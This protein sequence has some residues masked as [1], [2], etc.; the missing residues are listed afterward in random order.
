MDF[1][2]LQASAGSKAGAQQTALS[3]PGTLGNQVLMQRRKP[4]WDV[5]PSESSREG[6]LIAWS[7]ALSVGD[8]EIDEQ[9][10]Q[11]VRMINTLHKAMRDGTTSDVMEK[12]FN[13]LAQYT[14]DHF[15]YEEERMA[16]CGYPHLVEHR[17]QHVNLVQQVQALQ[18][19]FAGG[20]QRINMKVMN[21]LKNWITGHI[22]NSDKDYMPYLRE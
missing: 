8:P 12:L 10:Q 17:G 16:A 4:V 14:V 9:H 20:N 7:Q 1:F 15:R 18:E 11:L 6:V 3:T 2:T 5:D 22:Q 19:K 21:F 13:D